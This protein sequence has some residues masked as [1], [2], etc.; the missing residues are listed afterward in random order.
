MAKLK[1]HTLKLDYP[2]Y[3]A[4]FLNNRTLL[5][6]GGGGEGN[7]G[8]PNKMTVIAV[9]PENL[10]KPL[11][12]YRELSLNDKEDSVMSLDS[13]NGIILAGINENSSM[14]RKG[15]NKHLRK[16]KFVNDHLTFVQSCQIHANSNSTMYQ[17]ITCISSDGSSG[18]IVMS[19]NPS[20]VYIIDSTDDLEE[21]FKIM[22]DGD[23]KDISISPD[24]KL[25]CYITTNTFEAISMVTGRSLFK[26]NID[27][28]MSRVRFINN[29]EVIICGAK[30]SNAIVAKFS[31]AKSKIILQKLICKNLK[32]TTSM[33]INIANDLIAIAT[34]DYS[35]L[36]VRISDLKLVKKLN[37]VHKFAITKVVFSDDG[38]FL[39]SGSAANTVNVI[40]IKEGLAHSKSTLASIF[41]NLLTIIIIGLLAIGTQ[42]LYKE[43]HINTAYNKALIIYESYKPKDSSNY[44]VV[45]EVDSN[46]FSSASFSHLDADATIK[47]DIISESGNISLTSIEYVSTSTDLPPV[48]VKSEEEL[49][50]VISTSFE[51][52][53]EPSSTVTSSSKSSSF[54]ASPIESKSKPATETTQTIAPESAVTEEKVVDT[55]LTAESVIELSA[56][57]TPEK[58][59]K[60]KEVS[61]EV[62]TTDDIP[63]QAA[64]I[65]EETT[66]KEVVTTREVTAIVSVIE[67]QT[68]TETAVEVVTKT[69]TKVL[70]VTSTVDVSSTT[71][72]EDVLEQIETTEVETKEAEVTATVDLTSIESPSFSEPELES[73][74]ESS[75]IVGTTDVT[76]TVDVTETIDVTE[77]V[78]VTITEVSTHE[79][80]VSAQVEPESTVFLDEKLANSIADEVVKESMKAEQVS[81]EI[82]PESIIF[83]DTV[84]GDLYADEQ[85]V[86]VIKEAID[87]P[88]ATISESIVKIQIEPEIQTFSDAE[89]AATAVKDQMESKLANN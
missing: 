42:Y 76:K 21:K 2:I 80:I 38:K 83:N 72:V 86:E 67:T 55:K 52:T 75:I 45:E 41:Y 4:K 19:D 32:G 66:T 49:L 35:I 9:Q 50:E 22:T 62:S 12:R 74:S 40:E 73:L 24:G 57:V 14:M 89:E 28:S 64:T 53:K 84:A 63:K 68:Q 56:S 78:D 51:S 20:T 33:D 58:S 47:N 3:T 87:V 8:I 36:I 15:V 11:K 10:K 79:V 7:N 60:V 27:I 81:I 13:S 44:F 17:K 34:S 30:E 31:I 54:S 48:S 5:V 71:I 46:M 29:D 59:L 88:E 39:A 26:T 18:V 6:A 16:F 82:E 65:K 85:A 69:Q 61:E 77:V 43:G 37:N 23:V 1:N 70:V 25:M